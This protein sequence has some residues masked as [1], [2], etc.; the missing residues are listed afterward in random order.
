MSRIEVCGRQ[1]FA[2]FWGITKFYAELRR[3][4]VTKSTSG[5]CGQFETSPEAIEPEFRTAFCERGQ[6]DRLN[7][8]IDVTCVIETI[9]QNPARSIHGHTC[10]CRQL[11]T[12]LRSHYATPTPNSPLRLRQLYRLLTLYSNKFN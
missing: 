9:H 8:R 1:W 4:F 7:Y 10:F 11:L 12:W 3:E 2:V 5:G 6:T